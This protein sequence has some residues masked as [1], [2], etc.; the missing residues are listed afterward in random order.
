M[1]RYIPL[2]LLLPWPLALYGQT[3]PAVP[4]AADQALVERAFLNELR[5]AQDTGHPMRYRLRKSSPRLT[6]T[7]ELIETQE[8]LVA[9]LILVNDEPLTDADEKKEEERLDALLRDPGRQHHRK[10]SEDDDSERA[11]KVLRSLPKAF[12]YQPEGTDA[13]DGA[14][15]SPIVKFTFRPNPAFDP[16]DLETQ[17]LTAM[18][19]ELWIDRAQER[20]VRLEG[21]LQRDVDFGWGILGRL[22][23][24]GWI[25]IK[26]ADVGEHQ[27]R[28]AHFKMVMTGRVFF[29]SRVFDTEEQQSGFAPVPVGLTY[30]KAIEMLRAGDPST[31]QG[32]H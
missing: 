21:H 4:A 26:Q 20:V 5:A 10:Q 8:G 1:T 3:A 28:I 31:S 22:N 24:G 13:G 27:W 16:P 2:L 19:G 29:R 23:K 11:L 32:I 17:V 14:P 6:T 7:K 30:Q 18:T 15:P 9:R 25:A 12:I